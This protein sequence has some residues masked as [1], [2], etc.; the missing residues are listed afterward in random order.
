[1]DAAVSHVIHII[2]I[3]CGIPHWKV[4]EKIRERN[5]YAPA[6]FMT[7][8]KQDIISKPA[9]RAL[10]FHCHLHLLV[11]ALFLKGTLKINITTNNFDSPIADL[12]RDLDLLYYS[13]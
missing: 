7:L 12:Y 13:H 11:A 4:Q 6:I 8:S 1:M 10:I 3:G 5:Q 9:L 2:V